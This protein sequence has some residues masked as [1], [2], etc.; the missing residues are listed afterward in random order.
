MSN[1]TKS[2]DFASKDSLATGNAAKIVKGTEI[3]TEFNNIATAIAT[4]ADSASPS[5]SGTATFATVSATTVSTAGAA[6]TGGSVTGITDITVADG[7]T[8][9]STAAN[10]RANLGTVADTASNGIAARTA[11]NTLTARTITAGTG[12]SVTNGTGASGD[13]T[14]T[15]TGVTA[16]NGS[17]GDVTIN[18][19]TS[20]TAKSASSTNVDFTGI[21]SWVKRITIMLSG[22]STNGTNRLLAEV[23]TSS[24]IVATGYLGAADLWANSPAPTLVTQG[25]GI[26]NQNAAA[27][28]YH[29]ICKFTNITSN[30]WVGEVMGTLSNSGIVLLGTTTIALSG[31]LDRVRITTGNGT[32]TGIDT[33]DAGTINIL[34]E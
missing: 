8:G 9:A 17:S 14:I 30:T 26:G 18:G 1:Y 13:P 3:D 16:V 5:F 31:T 25:L 15:N 19:L 23:G 2:T 11:A 20:D 12:I 33:F 10:A 28:V 29:A 34:Y 32:T 4:K 6:I 27:Y 22:V 7:G 24:G 21:P